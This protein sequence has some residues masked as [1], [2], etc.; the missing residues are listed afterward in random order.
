LRDLAELKGHRARGGIR[1]GP[2]VLDG[3]VAA[4]SAPRA[5]NPGLEVALVEPPRHEATLFLA[6]PMS[7]AGRREVLQAGHDRGRD[8]IR[9]NASMAALFAGSASAATALS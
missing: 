9:T 5:E 7:F 8:L 1:H 3:I 2:R 6:N 4:E